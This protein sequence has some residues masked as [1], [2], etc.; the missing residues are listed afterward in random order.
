MCCVIS[1]IEHAQ[2]W[3]ANLPK[4]DTEH[5]HDNYDTAFHF[6]IELPLNET[7]LFNTGSGH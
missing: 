3:G 5:T 6:N 1:V 4:A 7:Q 2:W